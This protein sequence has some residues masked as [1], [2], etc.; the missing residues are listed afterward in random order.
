MNELTLSEVRWEQFNIIDVFEIKNG[1]YNKKPISDEINPRVPFLG[2]TKDNNAITSYLTIK[3]IENNSKTGSGNNAK[4]E[5]KY[6]KPPCLSVANNGSY[7]GATFYQAHPFTCS[8][9]V[10]LLYLK[11]QKLTENI[12]LFLIPCI[13]KQ[14]VCFKYSRKWRPKRM[15]K[16]SIMLPVTAE[17]SVDFN[18]MEKY[19]QNKLNS[20][21]KVKQEFIEKYYGDLSYKKLPAIDE[22]LWK[23]FKLVEIFETVQRGKRLKKADHVD[24]DIPYVSSS[25]INNGVNNFICNEDK[26]RIF[27]NCISIA[28]SGS[29]GSAFYHSHKFVASDHVTHLKNETF[30]KYIYMF[31]CSVLSQLNSKYNFNREINDHRIARETLLLPIDQKGRP[32]YEYMDQYMKNKFINQTKNIKS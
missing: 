1:F 7:V 14:R 16:S 5:S 2:A 10:N 19:I 9:D 12:A 28:N 15:V 4:I 3:D 11:E 29:V 13:E 8:H 25:G 26:V 22:K 27:E 20:K 30:T 31:L 6:F 17:G 21:K 23:P 32:D 18:F 24:G